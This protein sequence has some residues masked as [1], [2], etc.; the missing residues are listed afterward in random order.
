MKKQERCD[1]PDNQDCE[2]DTESAIAFWTGL[3]DQIAADTYFPNQGQMQFQGMTKTERIEFCE[4]CIGVIKGTYKK[5]RIYFEDMKGNAIDYLEI[6]EET[7]EKAIAHA[8]KAKPKYTRES[9]VEVK[10]LGEI[11]A[12]GDTQEKQ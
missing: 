8:L 12:K 7:E 2:I 6:A 3:R 1:S 9:I 5:Y 4:K 11:D 10:V